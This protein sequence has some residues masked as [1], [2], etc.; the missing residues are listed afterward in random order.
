MIDWLKNIFIDRTFGASRSRDWGLVRRLHLFEH[1]NCEVCDTN[2]NVEVHH[3]KPVH[4]FPKEELNP[5]NL[6]SLCGWRKNDCHRIFG[7]LGSFSSYNSE[8]EN[9]SKVWFNKIKQRP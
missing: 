9:D 4:L 1:P 8:I 3:K 2:K 7:H 6:I 5:D